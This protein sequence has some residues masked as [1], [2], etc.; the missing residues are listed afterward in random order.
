VQKI[1]AYINKMIKGN[2]LPLEEL[3]RLDL[4]QQE[5]W[6]L[7]CKEINNFSVFSIIVLITCQK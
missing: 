3:D 1:Q 4:Y 2:R 6:D 5:E 7:K